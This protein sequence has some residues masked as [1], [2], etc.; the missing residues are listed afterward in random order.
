MNHCTYTDSE[1]VPF[2]MCGRAADTA[3]RRGAALGLVLVPY[4]CLLQ[5]YYSIAPRSPRSQ[6]KWRGIN[7][8]RDCGC[9]S[10]YAS[11]AT[12]ACRAQAGQADLQSR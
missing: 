10:G 5:W 9:G 3:K 8:G 12:Y 4:E 11:C 7:G 6:R 2:S 1:A